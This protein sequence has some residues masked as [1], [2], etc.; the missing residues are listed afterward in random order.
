MTEWLSITILAALGVY[1]VLG[2]GFAAWFLSGGLARLDA[3]AGHAPIGFRLIIAPGVAALWIV[4]L[5]LVLRA[6][7]VRH[8][9]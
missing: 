3:G 6:R 5:V 9:A 7:R 4:L 8:P 2:V 1:A